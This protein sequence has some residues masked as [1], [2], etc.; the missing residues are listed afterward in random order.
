[1]LRVDDVSWAVP[2]ARIL[3]G[4]TC[5]APRGSL[6][7]LLGPN[8]SGKTTLLRIVA[9]LLPAGSG[10]VTLDGDTVAAMPR[11]VAARRMALLAQHSETDLD[12][13]VT[14]V[15]LLGRTPHRRSRWSEGDTDRAIAGQVLDQVDLAD[16]A[17]RKWQTLSGGERQRVQ[18]A[19]ALAQ[20]PELLLLD[21]PTNHLDIGHQLQLLHLVRRSGTT[22]LAALHDLN[23]A[24][25]FCD[26]VVVLDQG[27]VAASGA[28]FKVL[29]PDLLKQV[30][31]VDA[32]VT[33]HDGRP[34]IT[35]RR[36]T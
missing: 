23:L 3:D 20:E 26:L 24:A 30:Y 14:E 33:T 19:R 17:D 13:T 28:P 25:M 6:V 27:R 7:G 9:G 21:E 11:A 35:Y 36:P 2:A 34:V 4:V 5:A 18:L 12:L 10:A 1:M 31:G 16:F 15:V 22:T 29:T 32:D 8:G